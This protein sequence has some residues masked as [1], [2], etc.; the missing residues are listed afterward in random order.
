L[1]LTANVRAPFDAGSQTVTVKLDGK[2]IGSWKNSE[3][4]IW[5]KHTVII[6]RDGNRPDVSTIEFSFSRFLPATGPEPR[7][8]ALLFESIRLDEEPQ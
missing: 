6:P 7:Q 1:R 8:L 5:E 4:N 3:H 2:L